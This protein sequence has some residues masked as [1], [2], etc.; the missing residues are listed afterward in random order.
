MNTAFENTVRDPYFS[1]LEYLQAPSVTEDLAYFVSGSSGPNFR[2]S[3]AS[4]WL[5][6]LATPGSDVKKIL[7]HSKNATATPPEQRS[8]SRYSLTASAE[9][10]D[11]KSQTR[12]NGRISDLGRSGC[13]VDTLSP[14]VVDKDVKVRIVKDKTWFSAEGRI[15]YSK[16][17]MGMGLIFT[18]VEPA[19]RLILEKWIAA[20]SGEPPCLEANHN[21]VEHHSAETSL[22]EL[23]DVLNGII[24]TLID[25]HI[26]PDAK[27]KSMLQRLSRVHATVKMRENSMM[28]DPESGIDQSEPLL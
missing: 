16:M 2:R 5:S 23:C 14:F 21:T 12:I 28:A 1:I 11:K 20:L 9:V 17:G 27:G 15:V 4:K 3:V 24:T 8:F 7:H 10:I 19:D 26:L 18:V 6:S 25:K 13:Y 22:N